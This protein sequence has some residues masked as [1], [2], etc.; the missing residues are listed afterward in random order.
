MRRIQL[1]AVFVILCTFLVGTVQ[2]AERTGTFILFFGG[3][4][5]GR[6]EYS[7]SADELKTEG[8]ISVQGISLKITTSLKGSGE[9]GPAMSFS[10]CQGPVL[11]LLFGTESCKRNLGLLSS[12]F[13]WK[14]LL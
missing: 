11:P 7:W 6:E 2:A 9:S 14:N 10:R 3:D 5:A 13:L 1:A 4:E 8:E 12:P